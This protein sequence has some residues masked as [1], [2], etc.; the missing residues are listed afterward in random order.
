MKS[1]IYDLE[2]TS[3]D[4]ETTKPVLMGFYSSEVEGF[5]WTTDIEQMIHI[6]QSHD[7]IVGYNSEDFDNYIMKRLGANLS[8]KINLDLMKI[9]HGKGFGNDLGRKSILIT[10]DGKHLGSILH[11]KS[12]ADTTKALG[13][14]LKIGDFDYT[15]FKKDF[16]D[17]TPEQRTEALEYLEADLAATRYIYEYLENFFE[18]FAKGG[19]TIDGEFRHF[20]KPDWVQKK[21][22][23]TLSTGS[24][25]YHAV[26][27]L[28]GLNPE[29]QNG[30]DPIGYEGGFVRFPT[31][32]KKVGKIVCKDYTS[33]YP[34]AYMQGNLFARVPNGS[35]NSW[36]GVDVCSTVG[37]YDKKLHP[38]TKILRE[39]FNQRAKWKKAGD[40]RQYT[41][42]IIIN[43][44]YGICGNP[45]FKHLYDPVVAAD[46]T[47]LVRQWIKHANDTLTADGYEVLYGDTDSLYI[48]DP[49]END[50]R[51][52]ASVRKHITHI[53]S[54]MNFPQD[55]FDMSTDEEIKMM[56]FFK[57]S[58][59][60]FKK[61]N[62]LYVTKDGKVKIKGLPVIKSDAP[63]LAKIIY[64]KYIKPEIHN[65]LE[66]KFNRSQ[67][68]SWIE[69][70]M[71][72]D[73]SLAA[74]FF[75]I[76]EPSSYAV[77][78]QIQYQIATSE[79]Y[80]PGQHYM[81]KLKQ[82]HLKGAGISKNYVGVQYLDDINLTQIDI[83]R[84][85]SVLEPF[86]KEAQHTLEGYW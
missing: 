24:W 11:G 38:F 22:Y 16:Q 23:L 21:K 74:R 4:R 73:P 63:K 46:C 85:W 71:I 9:I 30:V 7:V 35:K 75:K 27:N 20:M 83:D 28:A 34:F 45:V 48:Y 82:P 56:A 17:L 15:L 53:K 13:G 26:C 29:F 39:I 52:D 47:G 64:E 65:K 19:I 44:F 66:L 61:K 78:S 3:T 69:T 51:L 80:G 72:K 10:P 62:Y 86:I 55:D 54:L 84:T 77:H 76:R 49:F 59:G 8:Y 58:D 18:F 41:L 43:T 5:R 60:N 14:P 68:E 25:V 81:F 42:K 31:V 37:T 36:K 50:A 67:I 33:A 1:I 57:G 32:E 2:T 12:L 40:E 6:L 70:E 79:Y